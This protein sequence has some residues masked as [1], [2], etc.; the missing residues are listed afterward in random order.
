M[1]NSDKVLASIGKG[2]SDV[3]DDLGDD[4]DEGF[5]RAPTVTVEPGTAVNLFVLAD[6]REDILN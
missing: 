3:T 1:D 5:N 6:I 2:A 4:I